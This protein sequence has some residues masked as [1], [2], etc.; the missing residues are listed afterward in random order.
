MKG[1]GHKISGKTMYN[2]ASGDGYPYGFRNSLKTKPIFPTFNTAGQPVCQLE[3]SRCFGKQ[4]TKA[5]DFFKHIAFD[6]IACGDCII[7]ALRAASGATG[8]SKFLPDATRTFGTEDRSEGRIDSDHADDQLFKE[9]PHLPLVS[10]WRE[11]KFSLQSVLPSQ[12][13]INIR[14][15][16]LRM[17]ERY[18]FVIGDTPL[19]FHMVTS[20]TAA[21]AQLKQIDGDRKA[22]LLCLND[23][24]S[25]QS[26][27][28]ADKLLREW[29]ER[30]WGTKAA[31]ER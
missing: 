1:A 2:F 14:A 27:Y 6:D 23:N 16:T 20:S 3:Y 31:W 22:A 28:Y 24:L 12:G 26:V 11:G 21:K 18:R 7:N 9:V 5:S 10:N 17:L 4:I 13:N 30:R 19:L 29:Q 15:W 8:L 25:G